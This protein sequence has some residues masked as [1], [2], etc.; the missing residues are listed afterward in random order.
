MWSVRKEAR[1]FH[2]VSDGD[3]IGHWNGR[4]VDDESLIDDDKNK[5]GSSNGAA[6][7]F[8]ANSSTESV[9]CDFWTRI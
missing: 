9:R 1:I 4:A 2:T 7:N 6:V 3:G 8:I 5:N